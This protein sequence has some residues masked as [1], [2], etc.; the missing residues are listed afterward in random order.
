MRPGRSSDTVEGID[1]LSALLKRSGVVFAVEDI[2][3]ALWLA[4]QIGELETAPEE[5][6]PASGAMAQTT[7]REELIEG[8]DD[9]GADAEDAAPLALPRSD[10]SHQTQD[11]EDGTPI[12]APAAPALRIQLDLARALRPLRRTVPSPGQLEFDEAATV[13]QIADQNIWSPVLRAAPERWLDLALVVEDSASLV[14]WKETIREF[15]LLLERQGAFRRV[16]TWRLKQTE[17]SGLELFQNWKQEPKGQRPHKLEQLL[18]PAKRR[19]MLLLSDCTSEGWRSGQILDGLSL[20]GEQA[21]VAVVQFLPER[22]WSQTVLGRGVPVWLSAVEP[23]VP[24]AKLNR[25]YRMPLFEQLLALAEIQPSSRQRLV[26]PVVPLE[27]EP[28]KQWAKVV[29]G[30]GEVRTMGVEFDRGKFGASGGSGEVEAVEQQAELRVQRFRS[31]ASLVAQRLA[32]LMAA[33]PVDPVIVDLIRQSLLR[34]AGPVHVAEVFMG[35]LMD[36]QETPEGLRYDFPQRVRSLLLDAMP[37]STTERVLDAV[38]GYIS[39]RL[40]L[41]TRSFEA[42]LGLDFSGDVEAQGW[43]VPFARVAAQALAR[44]GDEYAAL[45]ERV[46]TGQ[47]IAPPPRVETPEDVFPLLQTFKFREAT[48]SFLSQSLNEPQSVGELELEFAIRAEIQRYGLTHR[49]SEVWQLHRQGYSYDEIAGQLYI[50]RNTVKKHLKAIAL[51]RGVAER[52]QDEVGLEAFEFKVA[53][54]TGLKITRRK[55]WGR[56]LREVLAEGVE[57]EMVLIPAGSFVMG[58]PE[59]EEGR[60]DD[61]GPQHEVRFAEPFLMGKYPVTQAQWRVVAQMPQIKRDLN[62]DP[63]K[64]KGN[65]RPV[66]RV[67]WNEAVEFCARLSHHTDRQY[68]LPSEAEWEYACRAGTTTPFY[69]GETLSTELA[70]YDGSAYGAGPSGERRGETTDVGTFPANDFGLYDLHGNVW[71]WCQDRW[72]SNYEGAPTDGS[73]WLSNEES[74]R[75]VPLRGGSWNFNPGLCRSASRFRFAPDDRFVSLGLRVV[76]A[77]ART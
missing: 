74:S 56:Q 54:I 41:N 16:T 76:C 1:G 12:K 59:G 33:V 60:R 31:T 30:L 72:H 14:L 10:R 57:L 20:W 21:P 2:A 26:V 38:S 11:A 52:S 71:E 42:L 70:N 37:R 69:F 64:F 43:V 25:A 61:E 47:T 4:G 3:D 40:G 8:E 39:E 23:G 18:D 9:P 29:A 28:L 50:S 15:Q 24:S 13:E 68:R 77:I 55:K 34:Q 49:E 63:S 44:M 51:K 36:A 53:S 67:S 48:L 32:G 17:Q 7:V 75:Y 45:A 27:A 65:N 73:A 19:L 22:L 5:Q 66:E 46:R 6:R 58:S 62:P 35:G